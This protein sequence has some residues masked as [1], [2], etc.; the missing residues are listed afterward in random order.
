MEESL[1][2]VGPNRAVSKFSQLRLPR[3]W[4]GSIV[5]DPSSDRRQRHQDGFDSSAGL[6]AKDR[7]TIIKKIEFDI[8]PPAELL[9][10]ALPLSIWLIASSLCD[11]QIRIEKTSSA[12]LYESEKRVPV[13]FQ[14]IEKDATD[15]A[16]LVSMAQV[17]V[18]VAPFLQSP[19]ADRRSVP[20]AHLFP[21]PVEVDDVLAIRI[22]RSEVGPAPE[23]FSATFLQEGPV[24]VDRWNH[25]VPRVQHQRH[26]CR[27]EGGPFSGQLRREL[28]GEL[29]V[30]CRETDAGLFEDRALA[31]TRRAASA[32]AFAQPRFV[33]EARLAVETFESVQICSCN[34]LKLRLL[35][36]SGR[37]VAPRLL[38]V[39][40]GRG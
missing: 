35:A 2:H 4:F 3:A 39:E 25:G 12:I 16:T 7:P 37:L 22:V 20:F 13:A 36:G 34:P 23:P 29:T 32:A 14:I 9:K 19:V 33:S 11:G 26:A 31:M 5:I 21:H 18:L 8:A 15:S 1:A 6:Q 40:R 30:N 28:F 17:E 27:S 38:V 24:R 10:D